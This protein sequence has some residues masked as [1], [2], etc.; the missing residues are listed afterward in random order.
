MNREWVEQH[1]E[2]LHKEGYLW[3]RQCCRYNDELSKDVLQEVYLK[4]LNG[5]ARF[6]VRS[7][8]KTWFF[9]VI[10]YTAL[11]QIRKVSKY[12]SLDLIADYSHGNSEVEKDDYQLLLMKLSEKQQQVLLLA[13]YH[14]HTLEEISDIMDIS[15]G[16]VRTHYAR[17][18]EKLKLLIQHEKNAA[19][20]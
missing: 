13:F 18:K 7:S 14:D 3:A 4:I 15:V 5:K 8:V 17:G 1:L 6:D 9:A 11:E 20:E 2:P 10:R 16:S 12:E 19:R